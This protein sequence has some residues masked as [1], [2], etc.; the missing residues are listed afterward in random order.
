M[1][2]NSD[3]VDISS[4]RVAPTSGHIE[5]QTWGEIHREYGDQHGG[6]KEAAAAMPDPENLN[7][8]N[9]EVGRN[10]QILRGAKVTPEKYGM[11]RKQKFQGGDEDEGGDEEPE[12]PKEPPEDEED[13]DFEE[14]SQES[15]RRQRQAPPPK[16]K[17]GK[18]PVLPDW[19]QEIEAS[20]PAPVQR[21]REISDEEA[22]ATLFARRPDLAERFLQAPAQNGRRREEPED[23]L[24]EDVGLGQD[25][26]DEDPRSRKMARLVRKTMKQNQEL[27]GAVKSVQQTLA[28]ERAARVQQGRRVTIEDK[29][30]RT[31]H[32]L[33]E[34][35]NSV[36]EL[37]RNPLGE[38]LVNNIVSSLVPDAES[39][40]V[41]D[42]I[43][44]GSLVLRNRVLQLGQ[45]PQGK[46]RRPSPPPSPS[47]GSSVAPRGDGQRRR[48]I[49]FFSERDRKRGAIEF[50]ARQER[51]ALD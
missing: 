19:M 51:E 11:Q 5:D 20:Q 36:P 17:K 38:D 49:N 42:L 45:S 13:E 41:E 6:P 29:L 35:A 24:D 15:D 43:H 7:D 26:E 28:E 30:L 14:F 46:Q 4:N 1:G 3:A 18:G 31:R 40:S 23:E 2:R 47:S 48:K 25:E 12:E 37:Q 9:G 22:L 16:G 44:R 33:L 50:L 34:R 8:P 27:V 39:S 10:L 32:K 21:Q